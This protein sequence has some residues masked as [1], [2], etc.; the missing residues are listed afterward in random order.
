LIG[1]GS[2]CKSAIAAKLL[3]QSYC[4]SAHLSTIRNYAG[5]ACT[6]A[7]RTPLAG[8]VPAIHVLKRPDARR[9]DVG[10]RHK[11]GHG[12][13]GVIIGCFAAEHGASGGAARL[14]ELGADV[15]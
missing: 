1:L 3:R 2:R 9:G 7:K 15:P 4:V 13:L 8:L 5:L 14:F 11:A 6:P 12:V 10:A